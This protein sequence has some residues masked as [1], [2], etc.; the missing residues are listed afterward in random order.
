[1]YLEIERLVNDDTQLEEIVRDPDLGDMMFSSIETMTSNQNLM[2]LELN[3]AALNSIQ[4]AINKERTLRTTTPSGRA[5]STTYL[6][7]TSIDLAYSSLS[8][9]LEG[10]DAE[11][12]DS[13]PH[14]LT[15]LNLLQIENMLEME[16][17]TITKD[18]FNATLSLFSS[19]SLASAES[20]T[21]DVH[22]VLPSVSIGSSTTTMYAVEMITYAFSPYLQ[23][24]PTDYGT[25]L[26]T[27]TSINILNQ[28]TLLLETIP[29]STEEGSL[30]FHVEKD[31][32]DQHFDGEGFCMYYDHTLQQFT[33]NGVRYDQHLVNE[34]GSATVTCYTTH[35]SDFAI[36]WKPIVIIE[37]TIEKE[38]TSGNLKRF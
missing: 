29:A 16:T 19:T 1:M 4:A 33:T 17:Q 30:N 24:L 7:S 5:L 8:H 6:S 25:L 35:Y 38:N 31:L 37:E 9:L 36:F 3:Q 26:S 12:I 34:D 14:T 18:S 21:G 27:I 22:V 10:T 20:S 11:I 32:V 23:Y 28:N 2:D 15:S 13:V